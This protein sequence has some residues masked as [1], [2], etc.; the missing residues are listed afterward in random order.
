MNLSVRSLKKCYPL[1]HK[2]ATFVESPLLF[3]D[4]FKMTN[5]LKTSIFCVF[6]IFNLENFFFFLNPVNLHIRWISKGFFFFFQEK[7]KK[8][9][10]WIFKKEHLQVRLWL[11]SLEG[12]LTFGLT[13]AFKVLP[14]IPSPTNTGC[15]KSYIGTV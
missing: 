8:T 5:K 3:Q 14:I 11:H 13:S 15:I 1:S 6:D 4:K 7:C 10:A 12:Y 9:I 2:S